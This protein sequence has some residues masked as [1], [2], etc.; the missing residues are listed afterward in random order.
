MPREPAK[1]PRLTDRDFEIFDHLRRYR[2]TTPEIL[3]GLFFEDSQPNA[4]T[5]VTSRLVKHGYL[6]SFDLYEQRKYFIIGPKAA[7][8]TGISLNHTKELGP[9]ALVQEYGTLEYCFAD[10]ECRERLLVRDVHNH[11]PALLA[12]RLPSNRYY[13]D[14]KDHSAALFGFIRVDYGSE[15]PHLIRKCQDDVDRRYEHESF[16]GLIDGGRFLIAIPTATDERK[17]DIRLALRR[18]D[19]GPVRFRVEVV[20]NL[21]HLLARFQK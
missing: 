11:N 4:V 19:W 21:V 7:R 5:K 6:N 12:R 8:I 9:Q 18:R 10:K 2:L 16:R 15:L 17:E 13:L 3:H 1:R 14:G 20:P